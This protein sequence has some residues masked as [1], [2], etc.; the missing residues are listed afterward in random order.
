MN[1]KQI[2]IKCKNGQK[3]GKIGRERGERSLSTLSVEFV[4]I[5]ANVLFSFV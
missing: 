3:V 5:F 4:Q 1:E 2:E